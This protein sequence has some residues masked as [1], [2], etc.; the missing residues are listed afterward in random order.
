MRMR[1][2]AASLSTL[3]LL[4]AGAVVATA[5]TAQ[6][7]PACKGYSTYASGS[8][9]LYKPTTTNGSRNT[10]CLLSSGAGYG[11]GQQSMAVG[12]LQTSL[13]RCFGAGLAIDGM[14][15][16][17]TVNAVKTVQRVKGLPA[18]GVFGPQTSKYMN[19]AKMGG[20]GCTSGGRP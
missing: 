10:N 14:Y 1:R 20:S 6:A 9:T 19:W 18:D 8:A 16:Q 4:A 3:G 2:V 12:Y 13:N 11:G 17:A 15:G 7:A 5:G